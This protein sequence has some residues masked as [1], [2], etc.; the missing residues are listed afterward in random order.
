LQQYL[1]G[2]T[3]PDEQFTAIFAVWWSARRDAVF[4]LMTTKDLLQKPTLLS[5]YPTALFRWFLHCVRVPKHPPAH[6]Y[7]LK[8]QWTNQQWCLKN[9]NHP[10]TGPVSIESMHRPNRMKQAPDWSELLSLILTQ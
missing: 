8:S 1:Q 10:V 7:L 2:P 4:V 9:L 3:D 6:S 5:T